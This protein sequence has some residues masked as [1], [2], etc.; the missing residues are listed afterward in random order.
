MADYGKTVK[1]HV[2][3][4]LV[5]PVDV[6]IRWRRMAGDEALWLPGTDHAHQDQ[7][8]EGVQRAHGLPHLEDHVQLDERDGEEQQE[9]GA[10]DRDPGGAYGP[11]AYGLS[12]FSN[13]LTS[14]NGGDNRRGE[15]TL[16]WGVALVSNGVARRNGRRY[17]WRRITGPIS[18]SCLKRSR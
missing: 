18:G 12:G 4:D 6:L 14:F 11:Y 5:E 7:Q 16:V 2:T 10:A 17:G 3:S 9:Q 13:V 15:I 8:G 1:I